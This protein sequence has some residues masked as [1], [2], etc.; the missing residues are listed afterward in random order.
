MAELVSMSDRDLRDIGVNRCE[1]LSAVRGGIARERTY[2][3]GG[4]DIG[5]S[6]TAYSV[7]K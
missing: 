4:H 6:S 1:I 7:A 2:V 3:C 5:G